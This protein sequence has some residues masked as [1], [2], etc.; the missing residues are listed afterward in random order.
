MRH[1]RE[2]LLTLGRLHVQRGEAH[3][4]RQREI[5]IELRRAGADTTLAEDVLANVEAL[6]ADFRE[7]LAAL[8]EAE[9]A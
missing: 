5:V 9:L 1:R 8:L 4:E 2:R 7:H 6:L 3:V